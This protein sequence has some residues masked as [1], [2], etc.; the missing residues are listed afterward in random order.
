MFSARGYIAC[1]PPANDP[2]DDDDLEELQIVCECGME[3]WIN[4]EPEMDRHVE[5]HDDVAESTEMKNQTDII[6]VPCPNSC[7][8]CG[9]TVNIGQHPSMHEVSPHGAKDSCVLNR[10]TIRTKPNLKEH[11][12]SQPTEDCIGIYKILKGRCWLDKHIRTSHGIWKKIEDCHHCEYKFS[13]SPWLNHTPRM[14]WTG[15]AQVLHKS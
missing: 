8:P 12:V 6:D 11:N 10:R 13:R 9:E 3:D 1:K 2:D 7:I 5:D 14:P 15:L 4:Y